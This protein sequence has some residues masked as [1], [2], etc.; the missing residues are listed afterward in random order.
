MATDEAVAFCARWASLHARSIAWFS[1]VLPSSDPLS[2]LYGGVFEICPRSRRLAHCW[3]LVIHF[4]KAGKSRCKKFSSVA[5][6][7]LCPDCCILASYRQRCPS[8]RE[9][10]SR[11]CALGC[12]R[13]WKICATPV[14]FLFRFH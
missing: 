2:S 8:Y 11:P 4:G 10:S 6:T 5:G 12:A 13:F 3:H 14:F 7:P 9:I 1:A